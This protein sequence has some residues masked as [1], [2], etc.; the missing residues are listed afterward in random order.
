VERL[1]REGRER[2]VERRGLLGLERE[3]RPRLTDRDEARG[4]LRTDARGAERDG[5]EA[6]EREGRALDGRAERD[7]RETEEREGREARDADGR[8][9]GALERMLPPEE[10]GALRIALPTEP[11]RICDAAA[12]A[13]SKARPTTTPSSVARVNFVFM[14]DTSIPTP[15][16]W[17]AI[18]RATPG[19]KQ[20]LPMLARHRSGTTR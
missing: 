17:V 20:P 11:R 18:V 7:D 15:W 19:P 4:A 13:I 16:S 1:V 14:T 10:R 8:A 5:R 12:S 9:A 6:R 2:T 3:T